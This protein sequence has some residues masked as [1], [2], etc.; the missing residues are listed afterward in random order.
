MKSISLLIW[1]AVRFVVPC[2]RSDAVREA[3]PGLS[4][5]STTLPALIAMLTVTMG[6]AC[7]SERRS[8][9]PF[10]SM[11]LLPS[12]SADIAA[13][14]KITIVTTSKHKDQ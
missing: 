14:G 13:I 12:G 2:V 6:I 4:P 3:R 9:I 7:F 8:T 5:G 11:I 10:L 1:F